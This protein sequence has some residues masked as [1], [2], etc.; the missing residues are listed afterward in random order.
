MASVV[1]VCNRALALLGEA[2]ITSLTENTRAARECG[3]IFDD[4][5]RRELRKHIWNFARARVTLAPDSTAPAFGYNYQFTLPS[6]WIRTIPQNTAADWIT[7]GRKILTSETD[8]LELVYLKDVTDVGQWDELFADVVVCALAE[9]LAEK[10]TQSTSKRDA[11][12]RDY[13]TA[14]SEARTANAFEKVADEEPEDTWI[15]ARL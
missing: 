14:L 11:A 8:T 6:D 9:T 3:R 12:R 7:E 10:L 4:I 2:A 1:S 5:R 13:R 15:T